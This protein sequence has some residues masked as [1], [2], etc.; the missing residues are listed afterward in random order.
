[1]ISRLLFKLIFGGLLLS[2][3]AVGCLAQQAAKKPESAHPAAEYRSSAAYAEILER[4]TELQANLESL[5][6]DF[7]DDYPKIKEIRYTLGL[8]QKESD[9][10]AAVKALNASQM[11]LALGKLIVRK[12]ELETELWSLLETYKSEH[13]DVKRA[14]RKVDIYEAAIKEILG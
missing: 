6:V 14:K 9:R 12:I 10:L 2:I 1:M 3:S 7:T 11:T 5:L 13:P 8:M 4:K